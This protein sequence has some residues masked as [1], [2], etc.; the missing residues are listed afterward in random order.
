MGLSV[1]KEMWIGGLSEVDRIL[2]R[3]CQRTMQS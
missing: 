1:L 2:L 3:Y